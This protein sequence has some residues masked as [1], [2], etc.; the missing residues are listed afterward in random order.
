M[1][2]SVPIA[3]IDLFLA[4]QGRTVYY[5]KWSGK[6][7][8][9]RYWSVADIVTKQELSMSTKMSK[10]DYYLITQSAGHTVYR[11]FSL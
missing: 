6:Q 10:V 9:N 8:F 1:D 2:P 7:I 3:W 4:K 5:A 11:A